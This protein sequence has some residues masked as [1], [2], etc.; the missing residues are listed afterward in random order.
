MKQSG[1]TK[2][3]MLAICT[4]AILEVDTKSWL[5]AWKAGVVGIGAVDGV[6]IYD[7]EGGLSD[8]LDTGVTT[9]PSPSIEGFSGN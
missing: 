4:S 6:N 9:S 2:T 8:D 3:D 1:K 5:S 7:S